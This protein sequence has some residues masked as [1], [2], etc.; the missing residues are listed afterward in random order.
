VATTSGIQNRG[1]LMKPRVFSRKECT[2]ILRLRDSKYEIQLLRLDCMAYL[3][4]EDN[5]LNVKEGDTLRFDQDGGVTEAQILGWI[6]DH[7][8]KENK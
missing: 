7:G 6:K 8:F 4:R 5:I 2:I 1:E 3:D